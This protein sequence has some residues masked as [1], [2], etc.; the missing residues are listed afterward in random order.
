MSLALALKYR[1]KTFDDLIGQHAVSQTLSLALDSKHISHAYLFSGLRGSGKTS[2]ARIFSRCLQCENGPTSKPCGECENCKA[3]LEGRHMDIIEMDGASSRKIEDIRALI[4]QTKYRP[5]FGRFK[6]FIIDE[7]HMLTREAFN[8]LL[9]TLEEPPEYVKFILA[10]TDPLKLPATILSRTQHFRFKQI[11]QRL[12]VEHIASILNKENV[13]FEPQ[14]LE[15]IA[16]SGS[17]S[18]RDTLTLLDQ[19]IIFCK[20]NIDTTSV[21]DMLGVVDPQIF[22]NLFSNLLSTPSNENTLS[23]Q[24]EESLQVLQEYECEMILDEMMLF[25]KDKLLH[26]DKRFAPAVL[27]RFFRILVDSKYLLTLNTDSSFVLLLSLLKMQEALKIKDIELMIEDLENEI[28]GTSSRAISKAQTPQMPQNAQ[29]NQN[30]LD[31][32][33]PSANSTIAAN[34]DLQN[35]PTAQP[36]QTPQSTSHI[37][38]EKLTRAI[39]DRSYDLG[40]CFSK[41]VSFVD[42]SNDI[43][44]WDSKAQGNDKQILSEGFS[45][46]KSKIAEIFGTQT[47]IIQVKQESQSTPQNTQEAQDSNQPNNVAESENP[48]NQKAPNMDAS[49]SSVERD[50]T[51]QSD[52]ID[53][54]DSQTNQTALQNPQNLNNQKNAEYERATQWSGGEAEFT[55][56]QTIQSKGIEAKRDLSQRDDT[57]NGISTTTQSDKDFII[58]NKSLINGIHEHLGLKDVIKS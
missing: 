28:F 18:L 41:N 35:A 47:K 31:S 5:S 7:V 58:R 52:A 37:L 44:S 10:T 32:K 56:A 8:A 26:H 45:F 49:T 21:T 57:I 38:F 17:G 9:K 1:P 13:S 15:I 53:R 30:T 33:N 11:S 39:Y 3:A 55:S 20:G 16:R 54:T 6:I 14:A 29:T 19:A 46:I 27:D 51:T 24:V 40:E 50:L 4:E 12:V 43:L 42:F 48:S 25:L 2:S 22:E 23:A 36:L 34:A